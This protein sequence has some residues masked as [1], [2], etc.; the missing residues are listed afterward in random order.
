[1]LETNTPIAPNALSMSSQVYSLFSFRFL[2]TRKSIL[3]SESEFQTKK[4]G[5][6]QNRLNAQLNTSV[7]SGVIS[8]QIENRYEIH[9]VN[10][11]INSSV[12]LNYIVSQ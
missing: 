4:L 5:Y 2:I 11:H 9:T 8:D 7:I 12:K 3:D 6:L 1:M 10:V